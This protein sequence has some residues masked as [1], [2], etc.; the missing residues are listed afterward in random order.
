[1][2]LLLFNSNSI[3][4]ETVE[5]NVLGDQILD[6]DLFEVC[7]NCYSWP[8]ND[9]HQQWGVSDFPEQPALR[10]AN[11][12]MQPDSERNADM[13]HDQ[14]QDRYW[15]L[16][17]PINKNGKAIPVLCDSVSKQFF[18]V[19]ANQASAVKVADFQEKLVWITV[20]ARE[21]ISDF[22]GDTWWEL[23]VNRQNSDNWAPAAVRFEKT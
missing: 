12:T 16:L 6:G 9:L 11:F 1:M 22:T 7:C 23:E 13:K 4:F 17:H 14:I 18:G 2:S 3:W 5:D 21:R 10:I 19:A 20:V 15:V 8:V